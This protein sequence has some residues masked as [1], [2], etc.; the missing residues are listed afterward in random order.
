MMRSFFVIYEAIGIFVASGTIA[1][2][3]FN[4]QFI[5][6]FDHGGSGIFNRFW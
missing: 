5:K 4:P 1:R 6:S 2:K 3:W